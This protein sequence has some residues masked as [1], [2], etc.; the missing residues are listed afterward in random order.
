M[1][2][3]ECRGLRVAGASMQPTLERGDLIIVNRADNVLGD[4]MFALKFGNTL[5]FKTVICRGKNTSDLVWTNMALVQ[6]SGHQ[7]M[8]RFIEGAR[9]ASLERALPL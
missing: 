6:T 3:R 5:L 4:G 2:P 8:V 7:S 1:R 9:Y